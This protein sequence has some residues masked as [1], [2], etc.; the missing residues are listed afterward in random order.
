ME[1]HNLL[2]KSRLDRPLTIAIAGAGGRGGQYAR[3][4]AL[5]DTPAHITAVAD[6]NDVRLDTMRRE[7]GVPPEHLYA[8]W[9]DL[10]AQPRLAD[11]VVIATQDADHL[12]PT[13]AF[14]KLGYDILL[15]KPMAISEE[16]CVAIEQ[17]SRK[18]GVSIAVCHVLRYT[19]YT[20]KLVELLR[21]GAIGEIV[22][23]EHLEPIGF[24]HFAHS[25]VRGP[26]RTTK[27]AATMLMAK[28]CHDI[29]W[30]S[31]VIGKPV[32]RVSSFGGLHHF[33][34]D[35]QPS[36]AAD[37]CVECPLVDC[38][39][40][41][42]K[43]YRIGRLPFALSKMLGGREPTEQLIG[44]ALAE[45]PYGRCV[46]KCD[47]DVA[48]HQVVNL[49]YEGGVTAAFTVTAFAMMGGRRTTF[50][51]THGELYGDSDRIEITDFRTREK[52]VHE[53][54]PADHS[55]SGGHGGGDLGLMKAFV[56]AISLG[57]PE[58]ILTDV[59][60]SLATH[61]IVFAAERSRTSGEVIAL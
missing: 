61:R 25:Y 32:E 39:Y 11:A 54:A 22:S 10:A 24:D 36:G 20:T 52:T 21:A 12:E 17:A 47:N 26:W 40:D 7:H 56:E 45:S 29:D 31:Y 43:I 34:A 41:A 46:Y 60:E 3:M 51:G 48:D 44:E 13:V 42:R 58:L 1:F 57:R 27:E 9:R 53:T 37:K 49:E 5:L 6:A 14:A 23:V 50:F 4:N 55:A 38:E 15:E 16:E 18:Y 30:L 19:P 8:D 59:S 33:K 35:Q 28:S 2:S